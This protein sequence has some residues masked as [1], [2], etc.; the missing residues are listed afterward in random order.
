MPFGSLMN[1]YGNVNYGLGVTTDKFMKDAKSLFA[2]AKSFVKEQY[3][4]VEN[5]KSTDNDNLLQQ[6][7]GDDEANPFNEI[8]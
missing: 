8:E 4:M 5:K 3:E 6:A 1:S 7:F 2:L